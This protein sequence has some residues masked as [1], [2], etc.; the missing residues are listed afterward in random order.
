MD[1]E[2]VR[3]LVNVLVSCTMI[4]HTNRQYFEGK[5]TDEVGDWI[6]EQLNEC[7]FPSGPCGML[8]VSLDDSLFEKGQSCL[9]KS[10]LK[11]P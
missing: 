3:K 6:R 10:H 2:R 9:G 7:G 8:H 5:D 4:V 1:E 11:L